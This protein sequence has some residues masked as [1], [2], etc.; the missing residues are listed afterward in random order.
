MKNALFD[1]NFTIYEISSLQT[2]LNAADFYL[3]ED[4]NITMKICKILSMFLRYGSIRSIILMCFIC[5]QNHS[6]QNYKMVLL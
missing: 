1:K 6:L 3:E 4:L 5:N 2:I